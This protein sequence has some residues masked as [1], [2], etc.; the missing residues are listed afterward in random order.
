MKP[1][2]RVDFSSLV[3]ITPPRVL[4]KGWS[5]GL[6]IVVAGALR[7]E[8]SW[9]ILRAAW[10]T[11]EKHNTS[12]YKRSVEC[13]RRCCFIYDMDIRSPL[14]V[15]ICNFTIFKIRNFYSVAFFGTQILFL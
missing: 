15:K 3:F 5:A 10:Y 9:H 12:F 14:D 13:Q 8:Y 2:S 11:K 7:A 4:K 1:F 6:A